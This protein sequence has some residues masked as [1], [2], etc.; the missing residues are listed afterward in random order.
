[1]I[2]SVSFD[3]TV[4][5]WDTLID[6]ENQPVSFVKF[7]PSATLNLNMFMGRCTENEGVHKVKNRESVI[8]EEEDEDGLLN[9]EFLKEKFELVD[10]LN[11]GVLKFP[12]DNYTLIDDENQPVS[13]VKFSPSATLN[14]N[15]FMGRC[16]ENEGVHKVK[17]RE[18]VIMEEEDEDG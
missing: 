4:R 18:S 13:F 10:T 7:S 17:N 2:V 16:T 5:V 8:M 9:R 14:L 6:D 15:M 11:E 12:N 3:E 1:M